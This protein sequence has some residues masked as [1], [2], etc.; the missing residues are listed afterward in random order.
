MSAS[1]ATCSVSARRRKELNSSTT[2]TLHVKTNRKTRRVR[3]AGCCR[4][5]LGGYI[6]YNTPSNSVLVPG[7][8]TAK[9]TFGSGPT[10]VAFVFIY[11]LHGFCA[12]LRFLWYN[13]GRNMKTAINLSCLIALSVLLT[14]CAM[15]GVA[16]RVPRQNFEHQAVAMA[17]GTNL[18]SMIIAGA[19]ARRWTTQVLASD[20]VRCTF[21]HRSWS[22]TVDIRHTGS[23]FT[24]EYVDTTGLFY[25]PEFNDIHASYNKQ[26]L[27]L[28]RQIQKT[29][30][31]AMTRGAIAS[32]NAHA[33]TAPATPQAPAVKPYTVNRL[34]RSGGTGF[35]YEFS[36]ELGEGV[37]ADL[38]LSRRIQAD[39][40]DAVR[41]EYVAAVPTANPKSISVEFPRYDLQGKKIEGVARVVVVELIEF[42]F[43]PDT[44]HGRLA[45][46]VAPGQYETT[47]QWVR[48][49]LA[50]LAREKNPSFFNYTRFKTER[51]ILRDDAVLE[52][53][54]ST[55]D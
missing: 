16:I 47:R 38:A 22:I 30:S 31:T 37:S 21:V 52:V 39:I 9:F 12:T 1:A 48:T 42:V 19:N 33:Q 45:V 5:P 2:P 41:A 28:C 35:S 17:P 49:N 7:L 8:E 26:V 11:F 40:R 29:A 15:F 20:V 53:E 55:G 3:A 10:Q 32:N 44:K 14:G 25:R 23:E 36:I 34:S 24:V 50:S 54:F 27:A 43:D 6:C 18:E 51:E 46:K 13:Y 4:L